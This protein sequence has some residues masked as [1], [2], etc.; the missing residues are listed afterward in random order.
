[1]LTSGKKWLR[2]VSPGLGYLQYDKWTVMHCTW[3]HTA[4]SQNELISSN[5]LKSSQCGSIQQG[6]NVWL[7]V[8]TPFPKFLHLEKITCHA[9]MCKR[10]PP[11]CGIQVCV[12][13]LWPPIVPCWLL[14]GVTQKLECWD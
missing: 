13:T 1:L 2:W 4:E 5:W 14:L 8:Q 3:E 12:Q 7:K 9:K 6:R 10:G 11:R